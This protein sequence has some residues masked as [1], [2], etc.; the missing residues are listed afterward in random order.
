VAKAWR[1]QLAACCLTL[2]TSQKISGSSGYMHPTAGHGP[3]GTMA[4]GR[5]V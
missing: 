1:L 4:A 5:C 3:P 2:L